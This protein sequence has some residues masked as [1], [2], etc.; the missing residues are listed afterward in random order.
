MMKSNYITVHNGQ[1]DVCLDVVFFMEN[2]VWIAYAPAL[3]LSGYD[4][5]EDGAK[6]SFQIVLEEYL[7]YSVQNHTLENDLAQHGWNKKKEEQFSSL[8][9]LGLLSQNERLRGVVGNDYSKH[10]E[11]FSYRVCS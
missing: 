5:T 1:I 3:D 11:N 10:S 9:F 6:R 2:N 4:Y 7:R 8:D